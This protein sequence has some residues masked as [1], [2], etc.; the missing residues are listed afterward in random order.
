MSH[1]SEKP[2]ELERVSIASRLHSKDT[3]L[4]TAD[5]LACSMWIGCMTDKVLDIEVLSMCECQLYCKA[6]G[7]Q[8]CCC[9][10]YTAVTIIEL[11]FEMYSCVI[12]SFLSSTGKG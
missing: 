1:N 3:G 8:D 2:K 12:S 5:S 9:F 6:A 7:H 11:L 10:K 4:Q